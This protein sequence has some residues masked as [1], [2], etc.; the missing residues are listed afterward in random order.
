MWNVRYVQSTRL[1]WVETSHPCL[2]A[3]VSSSEGGVHGGEGAVGITLLRLLL[4]TLTFPTAFSKA[5]KRA[6]VRL[7]ERWLPHSL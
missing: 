3:W 6:L 5:L 2:R 7:E 4:R 1:E